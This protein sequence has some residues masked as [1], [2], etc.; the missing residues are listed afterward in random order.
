MPIA[1]AMYKAKTYLRLRKKCALKFEKKSSL[2]EHY[3]AAIKKVAE[4]AL[5]NNSTMNVF[6]QC[7]LKM[8][9]FRYGV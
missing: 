3:L 5:R 1:R 9:H 2:E 6:Q 7:L 4:L 8:C